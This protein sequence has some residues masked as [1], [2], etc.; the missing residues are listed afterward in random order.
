MY[1]KYKR[2][3]ARR[4]RRSYRPSIAKK[5]IKKAV[6]DVKNRTFDRRVLQVINR[7]QES[8]SINFSSTNKPLLNVNS[9]NWN[10][11][12]L[13][14]I[15]QSSGSSPWMYD[16][17]QGEGQGMR[18]GNVVRPI[19]LTLN[20]VIRSNTFYDNTSNYNPCP[21]RITMWICR[22]NKHLEDSV[23][24]LESIVDNSFFNAGNVSSG[25]LG[26]MLDL[27]RDVNPD[28]IQVLK[29]RSWYIGQSGYI[30]GFGVN[31][32]NNANQQYINND[33]KTSVM[34]KMNLSKL[35]PKILRFNDATATPSNCR[36]LWLM[37]TTQRMDGQVS[38]TSL[39]ATTG[40][41]PAYI[42]MAAQFT[43]KDA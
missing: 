41:I 7:T 34:F 16:I 3:N 17:P 15:P 26:T 42:D 22:I 40:P 8:K 9:S 11:Q 19:G 39:G 13:N 27:T 31:S 24:Q 10:G 2:R 12:V 1:G 25:F 35:L 30:S 6:R 38:F 20:G 18:I 4:P 14:L 33:A 37:F 28:Q 43:Y 29:K 5:A 36:K 23:T 21:L 32:P